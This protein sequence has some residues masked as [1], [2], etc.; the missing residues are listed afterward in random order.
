MW[1]EPW[2]FGLIWLSDA[3]DVLVGI[4]GR[5]M[6]RSSIVGLPRGLVGH[7]GGCVWCGYAGTDRW[8]HRSWWRMCG[9]LYY[10]VGRWGCA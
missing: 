5:G 4:L 10:M 2:E 6:G 9:W 3:E 8:L 7:C 1:E